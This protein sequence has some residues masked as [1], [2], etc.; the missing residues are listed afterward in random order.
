M[1]GDHITYSHD[2]SKQECV[3]IT[4]RNSMLITVGA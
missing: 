4:E 3:D 1:L 2:I